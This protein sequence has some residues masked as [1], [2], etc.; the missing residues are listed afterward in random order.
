MHIGSVFQFYYPI[1]L[2]YSQT[3]GDKK[4]RITVFYY[5]IKLH[6]SQTAVSADVTAT[7]FTT[8]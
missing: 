5:P 3:V 2:H 4:R 1:K 6:Y 7:S 8:L